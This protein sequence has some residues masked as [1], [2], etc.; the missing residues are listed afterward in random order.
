MVQ[1]CRRVLKKA[2]FYLATIKGEMN[3]ALNILS[4]GAGL[5]SSAM[6]CMMIEGDLQTEEER[7]QINL[8][9]N[10]CEGLCGV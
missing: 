7:G 1:Y 9:V 5:Q 2:R 10:E 8:F 3:N 6:V 4:L